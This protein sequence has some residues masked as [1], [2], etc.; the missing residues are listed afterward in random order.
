VST[1]AGSNW[2]PAQFHS[3][4][5]WSGPA[6]RQ[7]GGGRDDAVV[8]L[9]GL[10]EMR[11]VLDGEAHPL[12]DRLGQPATAV[13]RSA[14]SGVRSSSARSRASRVCRSG[15]RRVLVFWAYMRWSTS[16]MASVTSWLS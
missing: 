8:Q 4:R 13:W 7:G 9:G 2:E 16:C 12:P 1:T 11:L 15:E 10:A 5:G 14:S 3:V 6:W